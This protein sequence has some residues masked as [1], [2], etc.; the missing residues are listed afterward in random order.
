MN[1][2]TSWTFLPRSEKWN[3]NQIYQAVVLSFSISHYWISQTWIFGYQ[4]KGCF[5]KS[6]QT[7][8]VRIQTLADCYCQLGSC[9]SSITSLNES[10]IEEVQLSC[11]SLGKCVPES[12][13]V[14]TDISALCITFCFSPSNPIFFPFSFS[15]KFSPDIR[16]EFLQ[17]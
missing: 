11:C 9:F 16:L 13:Q 4:Q 7:N 15:G 2:H 6:T 17:R 14:S 10:K 1:L 8:T 3:L 12:S 5:C